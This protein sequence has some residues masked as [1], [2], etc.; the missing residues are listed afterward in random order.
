MKRSRCEYSGWIVAWVLLIIGALIL[1]DD[2]RI[3][4]IVVDYENKLK[5]CGYSDR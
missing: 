5:E 2:I 1:L 4:R 3:S